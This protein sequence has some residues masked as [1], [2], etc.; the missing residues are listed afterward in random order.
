MVGFVGNIKK[1]LILLAVVIAALIVAIAFYFKDSVISL[2][3]SASNLAV[4][5]SCVRQADNGQVYF[6]SCSGFF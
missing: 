4:N 1:H 3:C 2:A 5:D 6:V